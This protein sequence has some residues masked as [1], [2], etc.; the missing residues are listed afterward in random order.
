MPSQLIV[1]PPCGHWISHELVPVQVNV[2]PVPRLML[3]S[4][5]PPQDTVLFAPVVSVQLLV[6]LQVEVQFDVHVDTHVDWPWQV[7]V[8]PVPHVALQVPF[9]SQL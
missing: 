6:P 4:L 8:Q 7:V 3:Q 5:P 9:E 1:Q 2:E